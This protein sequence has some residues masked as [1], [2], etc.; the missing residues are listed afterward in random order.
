MRYGQRMLAMRVASVVVVLAVVGGPGPACGATAARAEAE[1]GQVRAERE[2]LP[3][4]GPQILFEHVVC[5]LGQVGV[6][7]GNLCEF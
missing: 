4:A 7:R 2:M 3:A 5:D 6:G 1:R